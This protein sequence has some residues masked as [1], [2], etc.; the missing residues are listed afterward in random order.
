MKSI[1]LFHGTLHSTRCFTSFLV[2]NALIDPSSARRDRGLALPLLRRHVSANR[3]IPS[4]PEMVQPD[5]V[6]RRE[7]TPSKRAF[8][9]ALT[10][11]I[12]KMD[13]GPSGDETRRTRVSSSRDSRQSDARAVLRKGL[14]LVFAE[15][16][17][18]SLVTSCTWV[19]VNCNGTGRRR[20]QSQVPDGA[21]SFAGGMFG[22]RWPPVPSKHHRPALPTLFRAVPRRSAS[23]ARRRRRRDDDNLRHKQERPVP[24]ETRRHVLA[25]GR[26]LASCQRT[27]HPTSQGRLPDGYG[28]AKNNILL[29]GYR[30]RPP[31]ADRENLTNQGVAPTPGGDSERHAPRSCTREPCGE[32]MENSRQAQQLRFPRLC[33]R[34]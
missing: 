2:S 24:D 6:H 20:G 23:K 18:T 19:P 28:G 12:S 29:G 26:F 25:A 4:T 22:A 8:A 15:V 11:P 21:G 14:D 1:N 34:A 33:S 31:A 30:G 9:G 27:Q 5:M 17:V 13:T 32:P 16:H 10:K 3:T 7:V